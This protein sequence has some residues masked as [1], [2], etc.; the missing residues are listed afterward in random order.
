LFIST[1]G[2]IVDTHAGEISAKELRAALT[3]HFGVEA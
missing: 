1:D 3:K 2:I